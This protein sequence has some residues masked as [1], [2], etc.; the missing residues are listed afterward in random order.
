LKVFTKSEMEQNP[1]LDVWM[2]LGRKQL[3]EHEML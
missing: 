2:N 1:G 3:R